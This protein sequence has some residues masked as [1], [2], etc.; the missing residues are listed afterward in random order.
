MF[1]I[2]ICHLIG[3]ILNCRLSYE[4]TKSAHTFRV[5]SVTKE[6]NNFALR[7]RIHRT[8]TAL[9]IDLFTKLI[10]KKLYINIKHHE[11]IAFSRNNVKKSKTIRVKTPRGLLVTNL[12]SNCKKA[13]LFVFAVQR[14]KFVVNIIWRY[15]FVKS[16]QNYSYKVSFSFIFLNIYRYLQ[17]I[18]FVYLTIIKYIQT[19]TKL[20]FAR[21]K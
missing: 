6:Q 20:F 1:F 5:H 4:L 14:L 13:V 17:K 9:V 18:L 12:H 10:I 2:T 8:R 7:S 16:Q 19:V 3:A 15:L 11:F 21:K